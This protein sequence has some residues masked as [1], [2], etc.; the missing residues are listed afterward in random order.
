MAKQVALEIT[1]FGDFTVLHN[2]KP[3]DLP[4]SKRSRAL[5]A[6]LSITGRPQRR[7][8]LCEL[9]WSIPD[10]PRAALRWALSKLRPIVNIGEVERLVTDR[11]RVMFAPDS[12]VIDLHTIKQQLKQSDLSLKQLLTLNE[13]I[14]KPFLAGIDL[15]GQEAFQHWLTAERLEV[16]N[17]RSSLLRRISNHTDLQ[18]VERLS[19]TQRWLSINPLNSAAGQQLIA[20]LESLGRVED[21]RQQKELLSVRFEKAGISFVVGE[22]ENTETFL[23]DNSSERKMLEDQQI[24]FCSAKDGVRLA[25]AS[26]GKGNP[27]IK[28]ANWL[29]HLELDW[30]APIWSPLFKTLAQDHEFIR[31]DER[32]NGLSDW[33]VDDLSFE[34]FVTDLETVVDASG[35]NKFALLGISQGASVSIEYAYR[36]PDKVSHLILFGGYAAGW[37]HGADEQTIKQRDAIM[38]LVETGWG[39]DNHAYRQIFSSTFMPSANL[40]E[41]T[42][43]NEFQRMTTSP[44]NAA[45]FLSVFSNIDVR[46]RL[47]EIKVPT[48]VI[49]SLRDQRIPAHIGRDLAASIPNAQFVGLDSDSHLLLERESASASFLDAIKQFL[50]T[51]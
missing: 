23:S 31:Y 21:A 7:D 9:F 27:I 8:R 39:Q 46:N 37:R 2:G 1:T 50:S 13:T 38:T 18:L 14:E 36:Y 15:S 12:L 29:S 33:D 42:W 43:F 47:S 26:V 10:D 19:W 41:L 51:N 30:N 25:Y 35:A 34:S 20:Q 44:E 6:Y 45:R 16:E 49:H 28:A 3:V 32:G 40:E 5:L 48:L 4:S 22:Q 17:L 11:E 24:R